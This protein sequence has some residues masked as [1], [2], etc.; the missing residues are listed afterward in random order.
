M[1]NN[2][3]LN[4]II[5][6]DFGIDPAFIGEITN[7]AGN[8]RLRTQDGVVSLGR[9]NSYDVQIFTSNGTWIKPS[10]G[11]N[12]YVYIIGGGGGGGAG[13]NGQINDPTISG[14]FG[15]LPGSLCSFMLGSKNNFSSTVSVTI[16][17]GGGSRQSGG[18]SSFG[19]ITVAGGVAGADGTN[20]AGTPLLLNRYYV[21]HLPDESSMISTLTNRAPNTNG[22]FRS[23]AG[24]GRGASVSTTVEGSGTPGGNSNQNALLIGG[25]PV[26]GGASG[27]NGADSIYSGGGGG[28]GGRSYI[29]QD[30]EPGGNG[31]L[32][33]AGG[34]G[35][36]ATLY[37]AQAG[38][39]GSGASGLVIVVTF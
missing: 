1:T 27:Q 32:Y 34:G 30:G 37:G 18:S 14:G 13:L 39:G 11:N 20:S 28:G 12:V 31:G 33:G 16:G 21:S 15:G 7:N 24:G 29:N 5:L 6:G 3:K 26:Y 17:S 4:K 10:V 2:R 8:I 22:A 38:A 36:G 35:G 9:P 25:T 19:S 23:P